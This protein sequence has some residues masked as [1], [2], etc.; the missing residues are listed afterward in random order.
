MSEP[1]DNEEFDY[2][3]F[4]IS[5]VLAR[6]TLAQT[7]VLCS[8]KSLKLKNEETEDIITALEKELSEIIDSLYF[9]PVTDEQIGKFKKMFSKNLDT[10]RALL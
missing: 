7:I 8:A 2:L 10:F 4:V 5:K 6:T 3:K 9:L 1:L